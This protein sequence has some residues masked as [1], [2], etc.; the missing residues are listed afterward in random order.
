MPSP[1]QHGWVVEDTH[2]EPVWS[3]GPVIPSRL[4]DILAGGQDNIHDD[5]TS[6]DKPDFNVSFSSDDNDYNNCTFFHI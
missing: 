5:D 4:V 3:E 2:I 1:T 6:D